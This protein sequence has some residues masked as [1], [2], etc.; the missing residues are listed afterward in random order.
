[1][2]FFQK[3][4][5]S[6]TVGAGVG[7]RVELFEMID[8]PQ[9]PPPG[10]RG[11]VEGLDGAGDLLMRRDTGSGLKLIPGVDRF[12]RTCPECG[13]REALGAFYSSQ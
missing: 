7:T 6:A 11:T 13:E 8:D 3:I 5:I 12:R 10:S 1:M 2:A 9:A 4:S